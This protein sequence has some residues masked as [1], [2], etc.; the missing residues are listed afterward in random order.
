MSTPNEKEVARL[1]SIYPLFKFE[2]GQYVK[3]E[4]DTQVL[5]VHIANGHSFNPWIKQG[6]LDHLALRGLD[7]YHCSKSISV[8]LMRLY[9]DLF[10]SSYCGKDG[11]LLS[12]WINREGRDREAVGYIDITEPYLHGTLQT[13]QREASKAK[14]QGWFFCSGHII[15]EPKSQYDYFHFAGNYCKQWGEQ[16]PDQRRVAISQNYD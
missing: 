8:A 11:V 15:A 14:Q 5:T 7:Q 3:S 9:P 16:H 10:I 12:V 6:R 1:Q 13:W 4:E 2:L